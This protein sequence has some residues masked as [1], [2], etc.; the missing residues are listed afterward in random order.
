MT[1][2]YYVALA[3]LFAQ[4]E[5]NK[6]IMNEIC[7][8]LKADNKSFDKQIFLDAIERHKQ[9]QKDDFYYER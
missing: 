4:C 7:T 5:I 9:L 2:K 3:K 8:L 1:K 6:P